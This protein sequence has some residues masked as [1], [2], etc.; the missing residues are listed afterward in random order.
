M[1]DTNLNA[2]GTSLLGGPRV[3]Y[4]ENVW[5]GEAPTPGDIS[6]KKSILEKFTMSRNSGIS[7]TFFNFAF[8]QH[9]Q[10][11]IKKL[12]L[13]TKPYV[14]PTVYCTAWWWSGCCPCSNKVSWSVQICFSVTFNNHIKQMMK[15]ERKRIC[16]LNVHVIH[17]WCQGRINCCIFF[18]VIFMWHT[19]RD[20][21]H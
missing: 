13:L 1:D 11:K 20:K 5:N 16:Q 18:K 8:L 6:T 19:C 3:C 15:N 17:G 2:K 7:K 14:H 12:S 10:L 4:P 9:Y 21:I